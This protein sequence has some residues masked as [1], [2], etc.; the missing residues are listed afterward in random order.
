MAQYASPRACFFLRAVPH[1]R[2]VITSAHNPLLEETQHTTSTHW[3]KT[4]TTMYTTT[5]YPPPSSQ[6]PRQQLH[7]PSIMNRAGAQCRSDSLARS[8]LSYALRVCVCVY[9]AL[10]LGLQLSSS[11][12]L[13]FDPLRLFSH[14]R[15]SGALHA[16]CVFFL[17]N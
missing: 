8:H 12:W 7:A 2:Q 13:A 14:T 15:S 11:V 9:L 6:H 5:M 3:K 10:C 16:S 17:P 1:R 4:S